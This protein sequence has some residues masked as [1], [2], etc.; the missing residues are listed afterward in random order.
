MQ[1]SLEPQ[2]HCTNLRGHYDALLDCK[3]L[4]DKK[5]YLILYP[6]RFPE[7]HRFLTEQDELVYIHLFINSHTQH[8]LNTQFLLW[9]C[10]GS[11]CF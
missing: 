8:L 10:A 5:P 3:L 7:Q 11:D 4:E 1:S 9:L 6:P 2:N